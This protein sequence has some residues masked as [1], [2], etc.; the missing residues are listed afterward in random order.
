MAFKLIVHS[1]EHR[2]SPLLWLGAGEGAG[3]RV[4]RFVLLLLLLG[5]ARERVKQNFDLGNIFM[6]IHSVSHFHDKD[7][8]KSRIRYRI[9]RAILRL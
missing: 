2:S 9:C 3:R 4:S 8:R 1:S 5:V 7:G 6:P